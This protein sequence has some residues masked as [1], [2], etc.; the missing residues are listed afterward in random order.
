MLP[1][2]LVRARTGDIFFKSAEGG[3]VTKFIA[4]FSQILATLQ[5]FILLH[6]DIHVINVSMGY[7]WRQN[8]GINPDD[9]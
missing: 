6:E 1:N 8:F 9:S 2:C 7:N 5:K 3:D 4:V